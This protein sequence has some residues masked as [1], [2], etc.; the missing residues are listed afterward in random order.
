[1]DGNDVLA[2]YKAT[3]HA[4]ELALK[5]NTPVLIEAM[6]YRLAAHSTSD[7]PTGYRSREEEDAWRDKDPIKRFG[8]YLQSKGWLDKDAQ[9]KNLDLIRQEVLAELKKAEKVPVSD[10]DEIVTDVYD[11]VP[12]HLEEQRQALKAHIAKYPNEYPHTSGEKK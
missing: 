6:T 1:V 10:L 8:S 7:D 11:A 4:R 2:I 12:W 9:D 5:D 3:Q